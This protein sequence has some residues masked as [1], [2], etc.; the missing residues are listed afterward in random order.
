M[1][2][3]RRKIVV[4]GGGITGMSAA[5]YAVQYFAQRGEEADVALVEK[6]P[7]LGG[8]IR[9]LHRD[10]FVIEQGPDSFLARKP[11]AL[12]L[13]RELG[14][15]D[16]LAATNP[17]PRAKKNYI[18]YKDKLHEMPPG[19]VLGIPT[20][21]SPFVRTGLVSPLGKLRAAMDLLLPRRKDESDESLGSFI[22][23][24]LGREVLEHI[25]EPLL[26]GIYA[27]DTQTLSLQATFPQFRQIER[28]HRSLMIGMLASRRNPPSAD[29]ALPEI[30]RK[31]LFLTFDRGLSVLTQRLEE[32]LPAVRK[33][34]G[35]SIERVARETDGYRLQLDDGAELRADGLI[36]ALPA[37]ETA[38]LLPEVPEAAWLERI[39]YASVANIALAYR[40]EDIP[41]GLD[42]SGFVV[43]KR[44]GRLITACTWSS[45]KWPHAA[46]PG[47]ALLRTYVGRA[48][49]QEWLKL[50]EQ[51]LVAG[52][53]AD[54]RTTMGI[55][56]DP[57]FVE[58]SRCHRS[59]PQ[60]PVGHR[61]RLKELRARLAI[62]L[63]G[64][65]LCG[66]GYEGVG[67]PD[68]IEQGRKAAER[69][70]S[71]MLS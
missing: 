10:G 20:A 13:V 5:F 35:R 28:E 52:V 47:Y 29:P 23:R 40:E 45:S 51:E 19:L 56:A 27:G 26:A 57:L 58:I 8:Q 43:P 53:K 11:A 60:Y 59:M 49:A 65:W 22:R 21:L 71:Y 6:S 18:L 16:R 62:E 55:A 70:V 17:N 3:K 1:E 34:M 54:L 36:L 50:S 9:T 48:N 24:R 14:L 38:R 7:R 30:A 4:A 41:R 15:E 25:T 63:P 67:I 2:G 69:A 46:P 68:C 44:E 66:A 33:V 31:S 64:V 61:E 32:A 42:G 39:A 12:K 37:A